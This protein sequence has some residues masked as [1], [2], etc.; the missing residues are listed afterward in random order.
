MSTKHVFD[1]ATGLVEKACLG[2]ASTNPDLRFFAHHK[3]LYN[4]AHPR[5][6][7]AILAGG[8]AG[9]E[10]AFSGLVGSGL[11]TVAVSGDVFASPSSKQICSGVDLAPTDKG[12]VTIVLNYTGACL[13]VGL[14]SE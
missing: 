7:V 9:H 6:K 3:V 5:D 4:A 14:A 11:V 13:K 12:I 1:D 10:P 8:G 2:V